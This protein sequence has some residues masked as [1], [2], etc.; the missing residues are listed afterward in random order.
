LTGDKKTPEQ[1][2]KERKQARTET[3]QQYQAAEQQIQQGPGYEAITAVTGAVA[4]PVEGV[5]DLGYQA[6]LNATVNK[7][8]KPTDEAYKRAYTQLVKSPK[9][10][11]GIAAERILSFILLSRQLRNVP[12]AKL[13]ST[14]MPAGLKGVNWMAAKG[15]R[16]VLEGI[17]PGAI[18]DFL[19]TDAKDGNMMEVIK[20][21]VPENQR[22][23]F[24]FGLSTDKYG[25]PFLNRVKSMGEGAI[26]NPVFNVGIDALVAGWRAARKVIKGGGSEAEAIATGVK[27]M[28]DKSDEL[29][30]FAKAAKTEGDRM[31]KALNDQ[32][33]EVEEEMMRLQMRVREAS[34]ED[35][36]K[37]QEELDNLRMRRDDLANEIE[38]LLDPQTKQLDFENAR[39]DKADD[40]NNVVKDQLH[41]EEGIPG[42]GRVSI[43]GA[44][45][46]V[47]TE[48]AIKSAG[49]EGGALKI[50]KKY[51][52]DVD[53]L[54]ISKE[55]GLS[56]G[57]VLENAAKIYQNFLDSIQSYDNVF[58]PNEG[59]VVKKLMSDS[60]ELL[61]GSKRGTLGATSETII[62]S[63]AIIADWSNEI[64][65]LSQMAEE[66]DTRQLA[67]F[68]YY[69]R[70]T[71]RF[72][73][74]LEFY[75]TGTQFLGGSLNA[76][77]LSLVD[78]VDA[79][80]ALQYMA[81]NE[82]DEDSLMTIA[83]LRK[84]AQEA[85]DAY[86]RGDAD[87]LEKMR[88][89]TRA[90]VLS[91]GDPTKAISFGE[92]ARAVAFRIAGRNFYNSILSGAKTLFRNG[93]TFYRLVE[94][95]TS[96]ALRGVMTGDKATINSGLAGYSSIITGM[97]EAWK[98][99]K[100]TMDT[101]IPI[102]ATPKQF[103]Q[104]TETL[105]MLENLEKTATTAAEQ[106]AVG[107]LKWHYRMAEHFAVP[108]KIMMG[109]DDYFKTILVRQRINELAAYKAYQEN[110][111]DW[112][113]TMKAKLTEYGN[114]I[115]PQ[116]GF[117]KSQGLQE[118]A[119]VGTFQSNPGEVVNTLSRF[120]S[121]VPGGKLVVPFIRTPANILSYQMEHLPITSKLSRNY[122]A[123]MESGDPLLIAEY[124]GRQAVGGLALGA[125]MLMASNNLMTGN[126]PN[127]VTEK[128]EY[129]RW[130]ELG[131]QPRS[132]RFGDTYISYNMIEPL[133]NIMAAGADIMRGVQTYGLSEGWGERMLSLLLLNVTSTI[134]E[135]SYFSG[136]AA[137]AE[138][139][140]PENWKSEKALRAMLSTIN[141]Q[142]IVG[143]LG[144]MVFGS[145]MRRAMSNMLDDTMREYSDEFDRQ[146]QSAIP[147][148]RNTRPA[149]ISVFTG[150]PMKN[151]N[152][153][154]W[155]ANVPFE[156]N[157]QIKDPV[158]DMLADI[159][160]KWKDDLDRDKTGI[161]LNAEQKNRL[162]TFMF[163]SGLRDELV[164]EMGKSY[165]KEDLNNW[166]TRKLGPDK[167]YFRSER[168]KIY[169][170]VSSIWNKHREMAFAKLAQE[171]EKFATQLQGIGLKKA[172]LEN[173]NYQLDQ[174][175]KFY[176]TT[177]EQEGNDIQR[178]MTY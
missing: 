56:T 102:Q 150:K 168:P 109:M 82:T 69:E 157:T 12:G 155:N 120:V 136:I 65:R 78:N 92:T 129:K 83:R 80:E 140:N 16:A 132:L 127:P 75:K 141:N 53:T 123:A 62:A 24:V 50:L 121:A 98:V 72:I 1:I 67:N 142:I 106:Q 116:T 95:P 81:K 122:R 103:I 178:L 8:L 27:T 172:Q 100:R 59:D 97:S 145:G 135:K 45:G 28:A 74:L 160:Y 15:K 31:V 176:S 139:A 58:S 37:L 110:P 70:L 10:D 146:L 175:Q 48:S 152:G 163:E 161:R 17:V 115:D 134:T 9:T 63:K 25:D 34:P 51:E 118:Y 137:M 68:N 22:D 101:G 105:A 55:S 61:V 64:Y 166:R 167:E 14:P 30:D 169:D 18:S 11:A 96:I 52:N 26:L 89:L 5:I 90:M 39:V 108:E 85:K 54:R 124:E 84:F 174:P 113:N 19:L 36:L 153:G 131:I 86:R 151:P 162:R 88:T 40:I 125:T 23:A 177:S 130:K 111:S 60:G 79:R 147:L 112:K 170:G 76:L 6:Y 165:F 149:V 138:V 29:G 71:D 144:P 99:A 47:M 3:Q 44:S 32:A 41:L 164:Q 77:R 154:P 21:L 133:S 2:A 158:I 148:Y 35:A 66:A 159:D 119:D 49:I 7:G 42:K 117:I 171:D 57:Q 91:G 156:I 46:R 143:R 114:A 20:D 93:G 43:H 107:H 38:N 173:G 73:G 4:K 87:G 94:G 104:R 13:G 128:E 126:W 33:N